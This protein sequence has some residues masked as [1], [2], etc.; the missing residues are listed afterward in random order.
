MGFGKANKIADARSLSGIVR[1]FGAHK[2]QLPTGLSSFALH[3]K[4]PLQIL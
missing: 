4:N 3:W 2:N 1:Q